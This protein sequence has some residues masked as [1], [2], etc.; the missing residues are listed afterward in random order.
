MRLLGLERKPI[1]T[2][3]TERDLIGLI[4]HWRK[5][6]APE[7]FDRRGAL[8]LRQIEFHVLRKARQVRNHQ[9]DLV[10]EPL[11]IEGRK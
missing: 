9:D 3:R 11:Q 1:K 8:H 5:F 2:Q 10:L 6:G 7:D 4:V